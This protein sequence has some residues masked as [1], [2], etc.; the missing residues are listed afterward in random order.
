MEPSASTQ[1]LRH[2]LSLKPDPQQGLPLRGG[3]A[4]QLA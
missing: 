2:N 1:R 3:V 4:V